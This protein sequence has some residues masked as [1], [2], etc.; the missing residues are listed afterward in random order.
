MMTSFDS[1]GISAVRLTIFFSPSGVVAVNSSVLTTRPLDFSELIMYSRVFASSGEPGMRGPIS[2]CFF[3]CSIA[4]SPLN[5][6]ASGTTAGFAS[7]ARS[8]VAMRAFGGGLFLGQPVNPIENVKRNKAIAKLFKRPRKAKR[9]GSMLGIKRKLH[10]NRAK[11]QNHARAALTFENRV[12]LD[13]SRVA[14][15]PWPHRHSELEFETVGLVV[16]AREPL[17]AWHGRAGQFLLCR[18]LLSPGDTPHRLR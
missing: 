18:R 15:A 3:T 16:I 2:T 4:R 11:T 12:P 8:E 7:P 14:D 5:A 6:T 13:S 9:S 10:L 1:P 17:P